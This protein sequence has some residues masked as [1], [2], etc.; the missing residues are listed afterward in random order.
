[1]ALKVQ[2]FFDINK[3]FGSSLADIASSDAEN[4]L[5][6][7]AEIYHIFAE[8]KAWSLCFVVKLCELS[9][10]IWALRRQVVSS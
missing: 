2:A 8:L 9:L 6:N 5:T 4:F 10:A 1:M 7:G 3:S